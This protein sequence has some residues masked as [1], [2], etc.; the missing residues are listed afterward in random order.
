MLIKNIENQARKTLFEKY[1]LATSIKSSVHSSNMTFQI[2]ITN[3]ESLVP[4]VFEPG[5]KFSMLLVDEEAPLTVSL[6]AEE[7]IYD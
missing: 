6:N 7:K 5:K 3:N 2:V 1:Q 4:D